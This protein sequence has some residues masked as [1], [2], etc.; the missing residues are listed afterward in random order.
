MI[1]AM[2]ARIKIFEFRPLASCT[3]ERHL[4]DKTGGDRPCVRAA[5]IPPFWLAAH[6]NRSMRER[7][8]TGKS[9]QHAALFI[10]SPFQCG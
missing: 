4:H 3:P 5:E 9:E 2:R 8:K 10:P 6:F 1:Y 7:P